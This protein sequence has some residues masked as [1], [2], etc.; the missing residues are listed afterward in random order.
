MET[1]TL[2]PGYRL[3]WYEIESILGQGG[4]GITYLAKDTNLDQQV[5][6]KEFFP[7]SYATRTQ[8]IQ[9]RAMSKK[10]AETYAWGLT[11]FLTEAQTLAKF[12]HP[13]IVQVF[14]V[15]EA[16][17]TAYMVMEFVRGESLGDQLKSGRGGEEPHLLQLANRLLDGLQ[18]IHDAGFIHR[19]IKPD[20]IFLRENGS[21]VL[22]DFG[23]ARLAIGTLTQTL[24]MLVSPGY[25]PFEQYSSSQSEGGRQGPWTD[26]YS[27]GATLYMAISGRGP[28][29]SVA[30]A[31]ATLSQHADPML[32]AVD[33]GKGR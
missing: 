23:S 17:G 14:S 11:R 12:R 24:T 28:A 22:L 30:R 16:N 31:T 19:D 15:F 5:A 10:N 9:V 13:C 33:V 1:N 25:A 32:P 27:L 3:L 21:P 18:L 4:F 29:D 6:I 20:N 8:D 26:L 2:P 7:T